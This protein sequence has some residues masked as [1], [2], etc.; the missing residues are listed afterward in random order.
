MYYRVTQRDS[1]AKLIAIFFADKAVVLRGSRRLRKANAAKNKYIYLSERLTKFEDQINSAAK[2]M[3][4]IITTNN[5]VKTVLVI[6]YAHVI[7]MHTYTIRR[8]VTF[9]NLIDTVSVRKSW[10]EEV[11]LRLN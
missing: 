2:N 8:N 1:C 9:K 10:G 3:G 7:Y 11:E 6:G 4:L 5:L